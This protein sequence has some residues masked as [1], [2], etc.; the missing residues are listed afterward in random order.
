MHGQEGILNRGSF[1]IE[2]TMDEFRDIKNK[3]SK[4]LYCKD[5]RETARIETLEYNSNYTDITAIL[6]GRFLESVLA[7]RVIARTKTY[8][9]TTEQIARSIV[10]DYC[11]N[12]A[13]PL[14]GGKLQLGIYQGLGKNRVYQ[15]TGDD[16][17]LALY[18][19]LKLDGLSYRIDYDYEE[20]TLTFNVWSG[21][22]RTENQEVNSWATFCKNYENI[23]N[24]KY[25]EDGTQ[26]KNFAYVAGQDKGENRIVVEVNQVKIGE[27]RKELY[28]DARDLQQNEDM[29]DSQYREILRQ[30][31]LEKLQ[32]NN[33]VEVVGFD[34]DPK[35]N[36]EYE[37]DYNLGD[38][39]MYRNDDLGLYVEN[40]IVEI[41][42]VFDRESKTTEVVF[43]E[44]Y[45]IKKVVS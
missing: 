27:E 35:S 43:G 33:R 10:N 18:E 12:C 21:L 17:S 19:L 34:V 1:S 20:D 42:E 30:R 29:T 36:L 28:V 2:I 25:S 40:R 24:D 7:D 44:D 16:I 9:G 8:S 38:R 31:G 41:S 45:N 23:Q 13:N 37:R 26:F 14:F 6:T 22:D 11:I 39:V 32:E 5:F 4:Y 15:N 3:N